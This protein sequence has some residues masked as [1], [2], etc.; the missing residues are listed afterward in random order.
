[1]KRSD[2]VDHPTLLRM[3]SWLGVPEEKLL[4]LAPHAY[5][6]KQV[7]ADWWEVAGPFGARLYSGVGPV[8]IL[9]RPVNE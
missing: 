2:P 3:P 4:P 9:R 5:V 1:M 6:L 7:H 8:E